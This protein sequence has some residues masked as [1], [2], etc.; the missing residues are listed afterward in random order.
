MNHVLQKI[1]N[2][3]KSCEGEKDFLDILFGEAKESVLAGATIVLFGAGDLGVEM[4][5]SLKVQGISVSC[6]CDNNASKQGRSIKGIPVISFAELESSHKESLIVLTLCKHIRAVAAQLK[7]KGFCLGNVFRKEDNSDSALLA[8]YAMVGTQVTF[9]DYKNSSKPLSILDNLISMEA[10]IAAAHDAYVDEKSQALFITKLALYASDLHFSLF[11]EFMLMFSE[12]I[13]EFGMLNYD[14]TPEDYYYFNNDV[15]EI[16]EGEVYV[17]VGAFDGDT[18]ESF[19][20]TC[21]KLNVKYKKI[22]GFEPDPDCYKKLEE[23]IESY[24]NVSLHKLGLWSESTI[25]EFTSS[26]ES[27]HEQAASIAGSGNVKIEVVSLDDFLEGDEITF[28]K[29]DPSGDIV[30]KVLVGAEKT[31]LKYKPK[32]ALGIYHSLEEFIDIPIYLKKL[33]P[34]YQLFLRHNT[35]HLCDTDLY[36]YI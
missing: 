2:K 7:D 24:E 15:L 34:E 26:S 16:E 5:Y 19:N 21:N 28:I 6:F 14:G 11:K 13:H 22:Y 20:S 23:N 4:L 36:G 3:A 9:V 32:L 10:K 29:M 1:V 30:N 35:Y 27:L 8:M 33:C 31:I 17:D 12:P 25:L 18:I